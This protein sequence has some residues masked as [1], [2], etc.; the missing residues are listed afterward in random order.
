VPTNRGP[1]YSGIPGRVG[2]RAMTYDMLR[3]PDSCTFPPYGRRP[4]RRLSGC[5]A[6]VRLQSRV[7][8]VFGVTNDKTVIGLLGPR[9]QVT[10]PCLRRKVIVGV[11]LIRPRRGCRDGA[12]AAAAPPS[13]ALTQRR[14]FVPHK[15]TLRRSSR[16]TRQ[17]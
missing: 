16:G 7:G 8:G 1:A 5:V 14:E 13:L 4:R 6:H 11:G 15:T 17:T 12:C 9:V 3:V 10:Y 2:V